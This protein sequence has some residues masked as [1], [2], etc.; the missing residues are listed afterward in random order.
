MSYPELAATVL[1][2]VSVL[3]TVLG[4]F[5]A[6]LAV[7]GY[8]QFR[9]MAASAAAKSVEK[10]L[11]DGVLRKEIEDIV[12]KHVTKSLASGELRVILEQRVDRLIYSGAEKRAI[13]EMLSQKP[14]ENNEY[15]E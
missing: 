2:A 10:Q 4:V 8:S 14:N 1:S 5:I 11:T 12:T 3:V 6:V 15:G 13:D 9:E 7:W